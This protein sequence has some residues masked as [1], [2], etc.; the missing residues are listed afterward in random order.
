M[1]AVVLKSS[2]DVL[3]FLLDNGSE[4]NE[5]DDR[6][7]TLLMQAVLSDRPEVV[8]LL[9]NRDANIEEKNVYGHSAYDM[10][11][12]STNKVLSVRIEYWQKKKKINNRKQQKGL[13][14]SGKLFL[15]SCTFF[16]GQKGKNFISNYFQ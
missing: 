8:Q 16:S 4:A 7:Q 13:R 12:N 3:Q 10:A 14:V 5:A 6:N 15:E 9:I 1:V 11:K 2:I